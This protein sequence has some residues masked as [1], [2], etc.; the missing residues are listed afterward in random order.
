MITSIKA[1]M[2]RK[3]ET[4]ECCRVE[5][6]EAAKVIFINANLRLTSDSL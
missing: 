5:E 2:N 4:W 6:L 1:K 3:E